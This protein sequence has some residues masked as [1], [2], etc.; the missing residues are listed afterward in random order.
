MLKKAI[1]NKTKELFWGE[2]ENVII[3]N[4]RQFLAIENT[5]NAIDALIGSIKNKLGNE[6]LAIDL[7]KTLDALS[8]V[9]GEITTED[10]LN[11]IFSK[12]CVGK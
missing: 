11:N 12:F 2:N 3:T 4:Q 1:T 8:Q 7:R 10:V 6:F 5:I 9:S